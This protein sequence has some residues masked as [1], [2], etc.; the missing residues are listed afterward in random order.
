[1]RSLPTSVAPAPVGADCYY[2][3]VA[4]YAVA[5]GWAVVRE[6]REPG[7]TCYQQTAVARHHTGE[8]AHQEATRLNRWA[9]L[10]ARAEALYA[11][12]LFAEPFMQPLFAACAALAAASTSNQ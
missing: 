7:S 11:R 10:Q 9:E 8:A 2:R 1:M 4:L 6:Q 12:P 3:A 5:P